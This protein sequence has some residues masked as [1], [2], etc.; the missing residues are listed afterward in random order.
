MLWHL[1]LAEPWLSPAATSYSLQTHRAERA[2]GAASRPPWPTVAVAPATSKRGRE[3]SGFLLTALR[4]VPLLL[5]QSS[6][7]AS[8]WLG[9]GIICLLSRCV[10]GLLHCNL[11][12]KRL[13]YS[14][15]DPCGPGDRG[16]RGPMFCAHRAG[17]LEGARTPLPGVQGAGPVVGGSSPEHEAGMTSDTRLTL[18]LPLP[19]FRASPNLCLH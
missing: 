9:E 19:S 12:L 13:L 4:F 16:P 5:R 6:L 8:A 17:W 2:S 1:G 14:S 10:H 7:P 18:S 15:C 11:S 3:S